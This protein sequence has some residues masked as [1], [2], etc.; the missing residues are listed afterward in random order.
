MFQTN[1]R[2]LNEPHNEVRLGRLHL[3]TAPDTDFWQ[4]THYGFRRDNGHALLTPV[5]EDFSVTVRTVA[6][7]RL[8]Y[9]QCG[10]LVRLDA[11]NWIK[12][13]TEYETPT[14]SRLGSVVTNLGFSDWATID[15]VD[16]TDTLWYRIQSRG[17][18]FLLEYSPDGSRW[19]QLRI[20]HLHGSFATLQV[21][22][23]ACSPMNGSFE[24]EFDHYVVG[25]SS[26]T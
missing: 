10:L 14:H 25:P 22:I 9:D 17:N 8:Q 21:G 13:S 1:H 15:L 11:D 12:T 2:W 20:A 24:A 7:P 23:Y 19:N 5:T 4:R 16:P 3:E 26:W 18:D 6:R